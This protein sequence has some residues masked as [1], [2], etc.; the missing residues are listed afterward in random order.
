M[1]K[2]KIKNNLEFKCC[3]IEDKACNDKDKKV[4]VSVCP[5]CQAVDVKYKFSLT[6][7]FGIVP[8]MKCNRCGFEAMNF[9]KWIIPKEKLTKKSNK[10]RNKK[11]QVKIKNTNYKS[12]IL[13]SYCPHCEDKVN[14]TMKDGSVDTFICENCNF[15]ID[16]GVKKK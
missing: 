1:V 5:R 12:K 11:K 4:E 15:E 3:G 2:K 16:S 9:P 6:N 13:E 8:R 10:I 7:L 14:V